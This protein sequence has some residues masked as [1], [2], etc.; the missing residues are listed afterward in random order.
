MVQ[1]ERKETAAAVKL[2]SMCRGKMDRERVRGLGG[3]GM[4]LRLRRWMGT[5]SDLHHMVFYSSHVAA[6][7][8]LTQN[9]NIHVTFVC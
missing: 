5:R 1:Q 3:R 9:P 4:V 7:C 2:Q 8:C 6:W